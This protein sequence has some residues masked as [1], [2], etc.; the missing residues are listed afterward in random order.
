[1]KIVLIE[2][3]EYIFD[4]IRKKYVRLTKEEWV[5]QHFILQLIEQYFYPKETIAVEKQ[6]LVG[7]TKRRFDILV[8]KQ[9]TPW[10][11][12]EC[13]HEQEKLTQQTLQQILSYNINL[14]VR[15]LLLTNGKEIMC[16]DIEEK[17]WLKEIPS[18]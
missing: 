5:R 2:N 16:F 4:S 8:Y 18:Y 14:Q 15:Y 1:M 6:L 10:M 13:K 9:S 12:I 11:I 7:N 3:K 17:I